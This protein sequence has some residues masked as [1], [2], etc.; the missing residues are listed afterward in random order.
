MNNKIVSIRKL[1]NSIFV[2]V[3]LI[4]FFIKTTSPKIIFIPFLVCGFSMIGKNIFLIADKKN[5]VKIFD[6]TFIVGFL[7]FWFGF[8]ILWCYISFRNKD[9]LHILI[10]LP[11]W[12]VG[13][14]VIKKYLVKKKTI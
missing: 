8:L 11:F 2:T 10:T 3:L 4:Y 14:Y 13:I 6:K 9:Y 12:G 1:I 7:L 5:I